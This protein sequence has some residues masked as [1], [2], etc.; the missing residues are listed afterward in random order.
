MS[1]SN[2]NDN[3]E[4]LAFKFLIG[5]IIFSIIMNFIYIINTEF[6]KDIVIKEKYVTTIKSTNKYYVVSTDN[7][8]YNIV[9]LWWKGEFDNSDDYGK[10][11]V[12]ETYHVKGYGIR[13]PFFSMYYK[14]YSM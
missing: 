12:G 9:N 13:V 11:N 14:I 3:F 7:K 6:E 10:I 4:I 8:T 2:K 5:F 1:F